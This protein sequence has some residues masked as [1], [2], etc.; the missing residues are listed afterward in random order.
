[1]AK[2]PHSYHALNET[3]NEKQLAT[4]TESKAK[5]VGMHLREGS[6]VH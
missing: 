3:V 5:Y 2:Q 6:G 1:M 4:S